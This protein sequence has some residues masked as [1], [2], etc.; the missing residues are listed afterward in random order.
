MAARIILSG[1][2]RDL[3]KNQAEMDVE[4]ESL[5]EII[6]TLDGQFPGFKERICDKRGELRRFVR[7]FVNGTDVRELQQLDTT[8]A[9]GDRVTF[10]P[11][12]AG[13]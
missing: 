1:A 12:I 11:A 2:L 4:G 7:V 9:S 5:A 13:G 3:L 8:I 6:D 10:V